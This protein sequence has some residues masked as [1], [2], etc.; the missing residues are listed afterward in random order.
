MAE[1]RIESFAFHG[2]IIYIEITEAQLDRQ[3][4]PQTASGQELPDDWNTPR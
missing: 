4:A 1:R 2:K 3:S